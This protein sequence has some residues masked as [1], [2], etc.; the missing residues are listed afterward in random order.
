VSAHKRFLI[1]PNLQWQ[2]GY[3]GQSALYIREAYKEHWDII[4]NHFA[5]K[6]NYKQRII[7]SGT[8]GGGNSVEG[9][10]LLH[11]IF[12]LADNSPPILYTATAESDFSL[13]H[14][15]GMSFAI[16]DYAKFQT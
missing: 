3:K 16:D 5:V 8:A 10:F 9:L 15:R 13:A 7:I 2:Y 1:L 4:Y 12:E 11:K 14:V 6:E